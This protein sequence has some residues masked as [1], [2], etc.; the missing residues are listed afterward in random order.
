[1]DKP[2]ITVIHISAVENAND[3][4]VPARIASKSLYIYA[5]IVAE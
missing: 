3:I 5:F 2:T 1:M 4:D